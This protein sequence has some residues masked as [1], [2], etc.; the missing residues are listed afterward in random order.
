M[1]VVL[2]FIALGGMYIISNRNS[3]NRESFES[4][5]ANAGDVPLLKS[6]ITDQNE[7]KY[8]I[9]KYKD[10][11]QTTDTFFNSKQYVPRES[12]QSLNGSTIN[13]DDFVHNN[14]VP[15]FGAKLKGNTYDL[16]SNEA[17]LDAMTGNGSL[18]QNKSE[19]A[20]LF[21]PNDNMHFQHGAPNMNDFYQSRMNVGLKMSNTKPWKEERVGPGINAGFSSEGCDGYNSV[22]QHRE[23]YMPKDVD[24]LRVATNPKCSFELRG[25]EGPA[26]SRIQERGQMGKMEKHLPDKFYENDPSMW[27][28][29]TGSEK[30]PTSRPI[31]INKVENRTTTTREYE[32]NARGNMGVNYSK[33]TYT[34][35]DRIQN[36]QVQYT[37]AGNGFKGNPV[38]KGAYERQLNNRNANC[39]KNEYGIMGSTIG[40][41]ISPLIDVLKPSRKENVIGNIRVHGDVQSHVANSYIANQSEMRI[42]N[43]HMNP[44]SLNHYN[45]Q[46]QG[47]GAYEVSEHAAVPNQRDDT[48]IYYTG[49]SGNSQGVMTY[50]AAYNQTNNPFK[51]ATTYNRIPQGNAQMYNHSTG[52]VCIVKN[53]KDRENN[54]MFANGSNISALPPSKSALGVS[55]QPKQFENVNRIEPDLLQAFK[56]NPYTQSLDSVA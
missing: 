41:V 43:R 48:S 16:S 36:S 35:S 34:P 17:K 1:E 52:N 22:L 11:N 2:P 23:T 29:T 31:H 28:T 13:S 42:T 44:H 51:E 54:R 53:D 46:N 32:G 10:P 8:E 37:P 18:M 20:P 50:D 47:T 9:S 26:I 19:Q 45:I 6:E 38:G 25:H 4:T 14:M 30:A 21:K 33:D 49:N 39:N 5:P 55:D 40:A 15:F 12:F 3:R 56:D 27:M 7:E 24:Q